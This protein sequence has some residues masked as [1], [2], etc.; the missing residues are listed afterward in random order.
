MWV[1]AGVGFLGG[2]FSF[3][4]S[5]FPLDQLPVGSPVLYV[6]LVIVGTVVFCGIPLILHAI[7]RPSRAKKD[8]QPGE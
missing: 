3:L 1:A 7:R 8:A 2:G 5:F 6:T 4:V